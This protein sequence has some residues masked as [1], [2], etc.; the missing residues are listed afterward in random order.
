[1]GMLSRI[2]PKFL[3][4]LLPGRL[5][6]WA[7]PQH[8]SVVRQIASAG[9]EGRGKLMLKLVDSLDPVLLPEVIDELGM[10]GEREAFSY[11]IELVNHAEPE[12][13]PYNRLKAIEALGR[14]R[15]A[16]AEKHLQTIVEARHMFQWQ[17]PRE[18]R[19]AAA[20]A[21]LMIDPGRTQKFVESKGITPD[22]MTFGPLNPAPACPWVRQR[23]YTRVVSA[24]PVAALV[25]S[26][27]GR[28]SKVNVNK[29]SLG[30]GFGLAEGRNQP[31]GEATIEFQAGAKKIRAQIYARDAD[32]NL[33]FEFVKM[34]L[35]ERSKLRRLLTEDFGRPPHP[36]MLRQMV[37]R[38]SMF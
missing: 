29:L 15:E 20:Q 28:F 8:D 24:A 10:S 4:E 34:E 36:S 31:S 32:K 33:S 37:M 13:S 16:R 35:D 38:A 7:R 6:H 12:R 18:L 11:L 22:E 1:V 26:G 27:K 19:I 9:A 3:G 21:L 30:G 5:T 17:Q 23:R 2:D 14:L 25:S